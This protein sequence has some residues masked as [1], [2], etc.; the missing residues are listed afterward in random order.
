MS[1]FFAD[2]SALVKRYMPEIGTAWIRTLTARSAGHDLVIAQITPVE[3]LSA[4]GRQYHDGQISLAVFQAF[5]GLVLYHTQ[6]QYQVLAL[7]N[8]I[9]VRAIQLHE[10]H[11]LRAYDSVQL[12]AALELQGRLTPGNQQIVFLSADV[13]LLAAASTEGLLIDNPNLHP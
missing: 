6:H 4:I 7:T 13:R 8:P 5:R 1:I 2:S 3:M 11:R 9:V 10:R 12:A